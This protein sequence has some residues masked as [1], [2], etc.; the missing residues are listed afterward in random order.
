M[1]PDSSR[2]DVGTVIN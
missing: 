1:E 2:G